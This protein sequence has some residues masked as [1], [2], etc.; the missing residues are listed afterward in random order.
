MLGLAWHLRPPPFHIGHWTTQH[1]MG[2][3][4]ILIS[5]FYQA[6]FDHVKVFIGGA[7]CGCG[8]AWLWQ[9]K[10]YLSK[11]CDIHFGKVVR[12]VKN[13]MLAIQPMQ[14]K[15]LELGVICVGEIQ[16]NTILLPFFLLQPWLRSKQCLQY[17]HLFHASKLPLL[18]TYLGKG[19][20]QIDI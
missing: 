16:K 12:S 2:K 1:H 7:R 11:N 20:R 3:Y 17:L 5:P 15:T 6:S 19:R 18:L 14:Y 8:C 13:T 4:N 10:S 9:E